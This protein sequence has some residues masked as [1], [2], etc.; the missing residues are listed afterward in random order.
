MHI[1]VYIDGASK[2]NP[3]PSGAGIIICQ[4]EHVLKN[5][6]CFIGETTNNV[7]EYTALIYALEEALLLK[8]DSVSINTDSQLLH[9]Q[10]TGKYRVKEP[11][12]AD[13]FQRVK[14]L[15]GAINNFNIKHIP[16]EENRGADKLASQAVKLAEKN[17]K[18]K[19]PVKSSCSFYNVEGEESP[20]SRGQRSG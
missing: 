20:G 9:R 18:Q 8:A 4:G 7:A 2:G 3:G 13:M 10:V 16:R 19:G 6:S 12:L 15:A 11:R 5:I 1:D 17:K 14:E